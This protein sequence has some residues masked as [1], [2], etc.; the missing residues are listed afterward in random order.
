MTATKAKVAQNGT[1]R[2]EGLRVP[3]AQR[4]RPFNLAATETCR[5]YD[6]PWARM[7][8]WPGH[9]YDAHENRVVY[10]AGEVFPGGN[11]SARQEKLIPLILAAPML[12][13]AVEQ[14]RLHC[15][16]PL[17]LTMAVDKLLQAIE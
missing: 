4:I 11:L 12:L 16:A 1:E 10:I 14:Y 8:G 13:A 9:L 2:P 3:L 6:G 7:N 17:A 5:W 15:D